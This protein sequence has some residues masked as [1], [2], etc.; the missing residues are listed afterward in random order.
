[1]VQGKITEADIP[2]IRL[3]ATPSGLISD[4]PQSHPIL[5]PDA[6]PAFFG[7]IIKVLSHFYY[8]SIV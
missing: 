1:M 4:P 2:T 6:I 8:P 5:I 7:F 3:G